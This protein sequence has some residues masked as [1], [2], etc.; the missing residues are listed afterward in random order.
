MGNNIISKKRLDELNC[1]LGLDCSKFQKYIYWGVAK[2]MGIEFTYIKI[3]E[4]STYLE[5]NYYDLKGRILS[6]QNSKIK[7]GYYHFCRMGN[8]QNPED[9]A[10]SELDNVLSQLKVLPKAE[11]PLALD[12][13]AFSTTYVWDNKIEDMNRYITAFIS[14]ATQNNIPVIL[15]SNKSF[16]DTNTT[17]IFGNNPLWVASYVNDIEVNSPVM[18]NGWDEW[19]IWQYTEKGN[20]NSYYGNIDLDIMK[21]DYFNLF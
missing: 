17:P 4:G 7:V 11:L 1:V 10:K 13:E 14:G 8:V 3:T 19:K 12:L 5:S 21:K 18:P 2:V 20:I 6:A 9:D 15:Y 16:M